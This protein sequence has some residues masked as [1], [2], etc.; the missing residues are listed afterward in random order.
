MDDDEIAKLYGSPQYERC[1]SPGPISSLT[2]AP[3]SPSPV[4]HRMEKYGIKNDP[5]FSY[6]EA[7]PPYPPLED[8]CIIDEPFD[9]REDQTVL[10]EKDEVETPET[11][12]TDKDNIVEVDLSTVPIFTYVRMGS[13]LGDQFIPDPLDAHVDQTVVDEKDEVHS[14]LENRGRSPSPLSALILAPWSPSNVQCHPDHMTPVD[15]RIKNDQTVVVEE[16]KVNLV[17]ETSD[18][19]S[20]NVGNT[21]VDQVV[22]H[23][24]ETDDID[25]DNMV[26]ITE[27]TT[28]TFKC[29]DC[30]KTFVHNKDLMSHKKNHH[31][32][33]DA[34]WV[35]DQKRKR[36]ESHEKNTADKHY[37]CTA[38]KKTFGEQHHVTR[39]FKTCPKRRKID[40]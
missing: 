8:Q 20:D 17:V 16:D 30:V 10:V 35:R 5:V 27:K 28:S 13:P 38:C 34:D 11:S 19:E 32:D 2:L 21:A 29:D 4:D 15:H 18:M 40:E 6:V 7:P 26:E 3:C 14:D 39:H 25:M 31:S 37:E 23:A 1:L 24:V 12:G 33:H 22:L 36:K 9:S